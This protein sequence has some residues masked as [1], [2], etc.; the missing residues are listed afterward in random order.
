MDDLTGLREDA[1]ALH[2]RVVAQFGGHIPQALLEALGARQE[3][4]AAARFHLVVCGEFG[5][6][7][8][9]LLNALVRRPGLFPVDVDVT[10]SI[11]TTLAW[12][13]RETAVVH[14]APDP[15]GR[16]P[17]PEPLTIP[18]EQVAEYVTEQGNP[19]N[20]KRV[21][22]VEMTAPLEFLA[23]GLVLVDTP[24]TGGLNPEHTAVTWAFLSRADAVLFVASAGE[25]LGTP[26]L[27]ILERALAECDTV[28]TVVT[29]IDRV[30]DPEPFVTATRERVAAAIGREPA[31][32]VVIGVSA[33]RE[34]R[35]AVAQAEDEDEDEAEDEGEAGAEGGAGGAGRAGGSGGSGARSASSGFV[36]LERELWGGLAAT[37]GVQQVHRLL[38]GDEE[39]VGAAAA[40]WENEA[41]A[42][43]GDHAL[44]D[45]DTRIAATRTAVRDLRSN[46][47]KWRTELAGE[48][49][50]ASRPIRR[51][52]DDRLDRI[53]DDFRK[54]LST[55]ETFSDPESIV[56]HVAQR[57]VEAAQEANTALAS[58]VEAVAADYSAQTTFDLAGSGPGGSTV[59]GEAPGMPTIKV[60]G[61]PSWFAKA[62]ASWF[63]SR[64]G[65]AVGAAAGGILGSFIPVIGNIVGAIV[66]GAGGLIFGW[67][68]GVRDTNRTA[69]EHRRREV[70]NALREHVLPLIESAR[71][72]AGTDLADQVRAETRALTA[73][74]DTGLAAQ[75]QS[76]T[77]SLTGLAETRILTEA[78]RAERQKHVRAALGRCAAVQE[79]IDTLRGRAD[80]L[81]DRAGR[82]S[83]GANGNGGAGGNGGTGGNGSA[84]GNGSGAAGASGGSGTSK[85]GGASGDPSASRTAGTSGA[86]GPAGAAGTAEADRA[87]EA[88]GTTETEG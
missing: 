22:A 70:A 72:Q 4:L 45:I 64:T 52:L 3:R 39:A 36:A 77:A 59:R 18:L 80:A 84:G 88:P 68:A 65:F 16:R 47:A 50:A 43:T 73:A 20:A 71:R 60:R 85:D 21:V 6:G 78:Q 23:S 76:L 9:S 79:A 42:L 81:A 49:E 12:G 24:G 2:R 37:C 46:K 61:E 38:D 30:V 10:T 69:A 8:S 32:L 28:I 67:V 34:H 53:R 58:A 66:G 87:A 35:A 44:E 5:R 48:I 63:G 13:E 57:L 14:F 7:K 74:L 75:D 26:E 55:E 86:P 31:D 41:Q 25:P 29:M 62:R 17:A 82:E 56:R 27:E 83:G 40:P 11:A 1:L 54:R 15:V 51:A 33:L 19:R